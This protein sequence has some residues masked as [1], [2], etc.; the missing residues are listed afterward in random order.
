MGSKSIFPPRRDYA[1]LSLKDLLDAREAYHVYLSQLDN[2]IATAIGR[3][4]IHQDD[5]YAQNPPDRPRP[6]TVARVTTPR[7]L[8]N[9]VIR[10]WSWPA[11][12]VF[13]R[14][15]EAPHRLGRD[16]VPSTL[17]LPDGRVVPTCVIAAPPDEEL[18]SPSDGPFH[19][20]R[21]LGGGYACLREHQGEQALGTFACLARKGGS[22]YAL[23]NRHVAGGDGEV[24]KAYIR[25]AYEPVGTTSNIAVDRQSMASAFPLWG[26]QSALLTLDAGLVKINDINDWT[27]Q[28]F[29][30]GEIGE[31]FDATEHSVTLDMIGCPVRAFGGASGVIEGEV[32]A[33]FFRYEVVGGQEHVTDMLIGPRRND[34]NAKIKNPKIEPPLTRPGDSGTLW[35]YDPPSKPRAGDA[36][37]DLGTS[38][39]LTEAGLHARRLR[40]LAMQWGGQ[41][42]RSDDGKRSAYALGSFLSTICR[43]LDAEVVRNWSLGHDEYWGKVG[44][45]SI[46]WKA[47]DELSGDLGKLM[48]LNQARIGFPDET[49][50]QGKEF[51]IGREG[52]VPLA[53]VPDYVW[54]HSWR[55][56]ESIQ[57]FADIDIQDING[58]PSMLKRC[59]DD[60]DNIAASVWKDYFDGFANAGVGPEEGALPFRVWQI[61]DAMVAYLQ[62]KDVLRFVAAAGVMAHY[63]GD[64][65]QPLH[66][67][68]LHHGAPPMRKVNGRSYPV[69]RDSEEFKAFKTT[70]EAKIHGIYEE[71]MLEVDTASALA[72]I[73]NEL[74]GRSALKVDK[75]GHGAAKAV[76]TLMADAQKRLEPMTIIEADDPSQPPSKRAAALWN[77]RTIQ[78]ATVKSL[79]DSVQVLAALWTSAWAQ[80]GGASLAKTAKGKIREYTE[81]ELQPVYRN[82]RKFVPSLS[83]DDMVKSGKFEPSKT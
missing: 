51:R 4:C 42:V 18:P 71:N 41:R 28:A 33:L 44:H 77:N 20:S 8:A 25:G 12:L 72:A 75:S 65:S 10:P 47:C 31:M 36:N 66:C 30:I 81:D 9:S 16:I 13:V 23:T 45:F 68:Y 59:V 55:Q 69:P 54:V 83:L 63:V 35:F 37:E 21:L 82:D 70:P 73:D 1:S 62:A 67:S 34:D 38:P 26:Q 39:E 40:P 48:K 14:Q 27:S 11:V 57:H 19:A 76:I 2:V 60:P 53:D 74:S 22:Y 24:V 78:K 17:Y 49:I 58:G 52:F 64:A 5:W 32:R 29:G 50:A 61:W 15:W 6:K 7:T 79:A 46:G 43:S 56:A 80:G 3:Y